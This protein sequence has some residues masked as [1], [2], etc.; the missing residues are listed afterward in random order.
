MSD[1]KKKYEAVFVDFCT[2]H[3]VFEGERRELSVY[4]D[5]KTGSLFAVE[6]CW[7]EDQDSNPV[8]N[9]PFGHPVEL[10]EEDLN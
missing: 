6:T 7:L 3:D 10:V 8:I 4:R 1:K 9:S 2:V 5:E